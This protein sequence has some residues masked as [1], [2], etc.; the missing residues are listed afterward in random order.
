MQKYANKYATR[1]AALALVAVCLIFAQ[2]REISKGECRRLAEQFRF[3]KFPLPDFPNYP[4]K[5]VR[6]VHPS[7]TRL[8]AWVSSTGA[9]I[10]L[11]DLDND[12]LPND[13]C[14]VDPRTDLVICGPVPI[15]GGNTKLR[16]K[17]FV[18]HLDALPYDHNTMAPTG[19]VIGDINED[20][21]MDVVVYFWGR[22]P[23]AFLQLPKSQSANSQTSEFSES[24]FSPCEIIDKSE[25]WYTDSAILSDLDGDGHLDIVVANYCPDGSR[26]LDS[27]AT[28]TEQM[29]DS[30]SRAFNGGTKHFL[31]FK[32]AK[33]E[34][35]KPEVSFVD[36][37]SGLDKD[38]LC[39]W[40][41]ALAAFDLD[42]DQ[43]P[44]IYL[45]NDVGPD[46]LLHNLSTKG[47][48]QFDLLEG[49]RDFSTPKSC[50][51]GKDSF[52]GMGVEV[53]D[54]NSDGNLD[55]YVSN[56]AS[57]Y[58]FL[59]NH[60]LWL[61]TGKKLS[62]SAELASNT[63]DNTI[64][65][66][67]PFVESSNKLGLAQSGWAWDCRLADFNLDGIP[68]AM[69]ALGFIKGKINRWPELQALG[70]VNDQMVQNPRYWPSFQPG[71]DIS[72]QEG[73][74][75][76]V[77]ASDGRYYN[78]SDV[79]GL[80]QPMCSRGIAIADCDGDGD[81][82]FALANQWET[83]YFFLNESPRQGNYLGVKLVLPCETKNDKTSPAVGAEATLFLPDGKKMAAQIDG[84]SG[85][86]GKRSQDL[87]F[88]LGQIDG[89]TNLDLEIA[90]RDR[91]GLKHKEKF[92]LKPGWHTIKLG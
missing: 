37:D 59:E 24:N 32:N 77:K 69:Q 46:R 4:H 19:S 20:G 9:A 31:L 54:I 8:S 1:L 70:S 56:I 10:A 48:L 35:G 58:K 57:Q 90:W 60:F 55:I 30:I 82:D 71:A 80:S 72:G 92:T 51:L 79:I 49:T 3:L 62:N 89:Q 85:H 50:V 63:T 45:A 44:E 27:H 16:Y 26:I 22:Q 21:L 25:R 65:Q 7:L 6:K 66:K 42:S 39:G 67:A 84:G 76:F 14:Q 41:T 38:V 74:A 15:N 2:P 23:M 12:G 86:A 83:S 36:A 53:C 78:L 40:T 68:E 47:H 87:Y 29:Y 28:G 91:R 33:Q 5:S 34:S 18:L 61:N 73:N 52:K 43:L 64:A 11:A 81:L 13:Y 88:G 17:P 75:F